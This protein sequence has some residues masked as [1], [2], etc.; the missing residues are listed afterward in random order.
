MRYVGH[1]CSMINFGRACVIGNTR[2]RPMA[3][4]NCE[5]RNEASHNRFPP[6][7]YLVRSGSAMYIEYTTRTRITHFLT[8]QPCYIPRTNAYATPG[9]CKNKHQTNRWNPPFDRPNATPL[10]RTSNEEVG[11][12]CDSVRIS[13][14]SLTCKSESEV[15]FSWCFDAFPPS[16]PS[17]LRLLTR[18]F[19]PAKLHGGVN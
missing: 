11:L 10:T 13:S 15:G 17:L 8:P 19:N 3:L 5:V 12:L 9:Q 1:Q 7:T 4:E 16:S 6:I 14:T 2:G 18:I